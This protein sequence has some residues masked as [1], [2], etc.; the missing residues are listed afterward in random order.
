[1]AIR[2]DGELYITIDMFIDFSEEHQMLRDLARK[3]ADNVLRPLSE[4]IDKKS[5]V[6]REIIEQAAE[7]GFMGVPFPEEYGGAG[8]GETGYCIL[9]EELAKGCFSTAA[10]IGGH[11]SLGAMALHL[12]GSE[13]LKHRFMPD[14]CSGK[15]LAAFALTEPQA[16]S[17]IVNLRTTAEK[18]SDRYILNGQ[19]AFITNGGIADIYIVFAVTDKDAG[20]GGIS[21]FV[22][23]S[24]T[25]GFNPGK[26]ED[27]M[28]L[29]GSPT[30]DL[31]F[32]EVEVPAKNLVGEESQGYKIAL[33][34]L[35]A[36]RLS[37]G[38]QCLG[39]AK[40]ALAHS[41]EYA[42][43]REQFGKPIARFQAVQWMLADM[44]TDIF[45]MENIL[46]RT[47]AMSDRGMP[48]TRESAMVKLFCSEALDRCVDKAVQIHGGMGYMRE[49]PVERLYRDARVTRIFEGTSEIQRIVIANSLLREGKW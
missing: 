27:K 47:T 42:K 26:P 23:E 40:E 33:M 25:P 8:M 7:L 22:V 14:L 4:E 31:F 19:K 1:M 6:P 43:V 17:D 46:Y 5:H 10:I 15:K 34:T 48:Y 21:A 29:R 3:F 13:E 41:V 35:D 45:C 39:V 24:D 12:G 30:T 36:G 37:L 16:G 11:A 28:G 9:L 20:K 38:A 2:N 49:C 32:E 44:A 18:K